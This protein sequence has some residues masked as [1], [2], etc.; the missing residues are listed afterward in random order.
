MHTNFICWHSEYVALCGRTDLM[1]FHST[2]PIDQ[3]S[4][5][6]LCLASGLLILIQHSAPVFLVLRLL[7]PWRW[8]S[9][10][11]ILALT[12][13]VLSGADCPYLLFWDF[14]VDFAPLPLLTDI[15][16]VLQEASN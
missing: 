1:G 11:H 4:Q 6:A 10:A 7:Y 12:V 2:E 3:G 13:T 5:P 14:D 8:R 9:G 15:L 16:E